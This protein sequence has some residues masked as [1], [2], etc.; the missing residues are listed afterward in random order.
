MGKSSEKGKSSWNWVDV[1]FG[2]YASEKSKNITEKNLNRIKDT[3]HSI[4]QEYDDGTLDGTTGRFRRGLASLLGFKW[5]E[6]EGWSG[7]FVKI[8][9]CFVLF[10]IFPAIPMFMVMGVLYKFSQLGF[11]YTKL[12]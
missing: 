5:E 2:M 4:K 1:K 6:L 8:F 11:H 7:W 3:G 10:C 9:I 12:L